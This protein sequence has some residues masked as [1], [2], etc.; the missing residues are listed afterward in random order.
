MRAPFSQKCIGLSSAAT[1]RC[2]SA[3]TSASSCRSQARLARNQNP[4]ASTCLIPPSIARVP[5]LPANAVDGMT[6]G[7]SKI[8]STGRNATAVASSRSGGS[9]RRGR[10]EFAVL[11]YIGGQTREQQEVNSPIADQAHQGRSGQAP[12]RQ[13]RL[14][15]EQP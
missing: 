7:G 5:P 12:A 13:D 1:V 9:N 15:I 2:N 11:K 8:V 3:T 10:L 14:G 6:A 4:P